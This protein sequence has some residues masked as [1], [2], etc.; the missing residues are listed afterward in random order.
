MKATFTIALLG[1]FLT[2]CGGS[3]PPATTTT[4]AIPAPSAAAASNANAAPANANA[5]KAKP[6]DSGPTRISFGKGQTSGSENV[7]LAPGESKK[8]VIGVGEGQLLSINSSA[9]EAT[10]SVLTKGK[11]TDV[12]ESDGSYNAMT[13]SKGDLV[14]QITNG[15]KKPFKSSVRVEINSQ[16]E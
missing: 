11:T 8:F 15:T 9:S 6:A 4:N 14:F 12:S 1:L 2:A 3:T 7:T 5:N 16:G 10:I 13:T